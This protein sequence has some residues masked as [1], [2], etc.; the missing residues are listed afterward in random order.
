MSYLCEICGK[1]NEVG[2]SQKHGRGVAGK[3]WKKRAQQT[4]RLFK[5]NL[6]K[7]TL[8]FSDGTQKPSRLCTKC[9]KRIKKFGSIKSYK[10][11]SIL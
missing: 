5:A 7:Y 1:T 8:S 2:R 6:Q 9:A 10:N 11:I 3:R 4:P